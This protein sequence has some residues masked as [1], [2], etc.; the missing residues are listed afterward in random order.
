[1]NDLA[2]SPSKIGSSPL[3]QA[4]AAEKRTEKFFSRKIP[5]NPLKSLD[6]DEI[7]RDFAISMTYP[8]GEGKTGPLILKGFLAP[9]P[10]RADPPSHYGSPGP[11]FGSAAPIIP[12]GV[13]PRSK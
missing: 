4:N 5:R 8:E 1:M 9:L 6:S 3:R 7:V 10:H 2:A 13:L 11:A 12:P